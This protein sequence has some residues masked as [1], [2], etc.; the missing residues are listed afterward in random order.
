[1][2]SWP[3]TLP[4]Y[5]ILDGQSSGLG[6]GRVRSQT[7]SGTPKVRRRF[8]KVPQPLSG[9]MIMS[10]SQLQDFKDFVE[11]DLA[12]GSLPFELPSQEDMTTWVVQFA[13]SMPSWSRAGP[14]FM[15]KMDLVILP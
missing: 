14:H 6:D 10:Y 7:D 12:G 1:M 8:S 5:L 13:D 11:E 2:K 4:Q 9:T 3:A 15:V